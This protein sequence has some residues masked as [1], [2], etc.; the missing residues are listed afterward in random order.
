MCGCAAAQ[1]TG[2]SYTVATS[3]Q[4]LEEL[5]LAHAAPPPAP[6]GSLSASLVRMGFPQKASEADSAAAFVGERPVY[7]LS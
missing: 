1:E 2:G 7:Q 6:P 4:H 3:E 5:V